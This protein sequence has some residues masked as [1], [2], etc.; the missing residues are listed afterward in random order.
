[1]SPSLRLLWFLAHLG[2]IAVGISMPTS[3]WHSFVNWAL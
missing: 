2:G 1:M 3:G